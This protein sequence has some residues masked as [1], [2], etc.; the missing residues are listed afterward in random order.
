MTARTM[1]AR[2][3]GSCRGCDKRF[4]KG[5]SIVFA[6]KRQAYHEG[7]YSGSTVEATPRKADGCPT[8]DGHGKLGG[9]LPCRS[10]DSTGSRSVYDFARLTDAERD[11]Y[12]DDHDDSAEGKVQRRDTDGTPLAMTRNGWRRG[13]EATGHRCIDAPC[14]GC[15]D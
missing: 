10:C 15:C 9:G 5:T 1:T 3:A 13:Y 7:C 11:A 12:R 6:G 4:P 2:Y 8:C 14:C